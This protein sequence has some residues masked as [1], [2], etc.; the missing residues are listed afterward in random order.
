LLTLTNTADILN[1]I[2]SIII[3]YTIGSFP[4]AYLLLRKTRGIDITKNGSGNVGAMNS[5]E[6]SKSKRIGIVVFAIDALKGWFSSFLPFILFGNDFIYPM[7]G[8]TSSVFSHCYSPWLKFK[9]G[10]GLA[11]AAGGSFFISLSVSFVWGLIWVITFLIKKNIHL[12]NII[13]TVGTGVISFFITE[14]MIEYSF[15]APKAPGMFSYSVSFL[16]LIIFS[17]H[18]IPLV[19]Y[20]KNLKTNKD[21]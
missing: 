8:L 11:T 9:G 18:I 3:G 14:A 12:G 16:M 17:K 2:Y 10:R 1:I 4:T 21:K 20:I 5:Y 13:A 19:D 7:I 15:I 6:V